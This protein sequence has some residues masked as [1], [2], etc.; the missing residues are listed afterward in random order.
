MAAA[1]LMA[2]V[3]LPTP[4]FWLVILKIAVITRFVRFWRAASTA[5]TRTPRRRGGVQTHNFLAAKSIRRRQ[6]NLYGMSRARGKMERSD[7]IPSEARNPLIFDLS[8][9][10]NA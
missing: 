1:K 2:V 3:V 6:S 8:V 4:P 9:G 7:V 5:R 10:A